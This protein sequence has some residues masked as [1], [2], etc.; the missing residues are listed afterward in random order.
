MPLGTLQVLTSLRNLLSSLA[1]A[2]YIIFSLSEL[3]RSKTTG[4]FDDSGNFEFLN[5]FHTGRTH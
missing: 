2:E 4:I 1:I 3:S 5:R